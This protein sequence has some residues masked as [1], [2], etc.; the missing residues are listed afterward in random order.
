M[1]TDE[2]QHEQVDEGRVDDVDREHY[3]DGAA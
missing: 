3:T 2:T 1:D